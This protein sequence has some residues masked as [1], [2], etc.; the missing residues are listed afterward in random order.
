[1]VDHHVP[2]K[3]GALE[4]LDLLDELRLPRAIAT[5]SSRP[6]VLD[7]LG[8]HGIADR[9][10]HI[11]AHGDY[12]LAKPA[13]EPFLKAAGTWVWRRDFAWP[14]RIPTMQAEMKYSTA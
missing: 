7:H 13:P 12:T 4:L 5:T 2:V 10:H 11:V 8:R 9:F 14:W 1:M 6:T 3:P